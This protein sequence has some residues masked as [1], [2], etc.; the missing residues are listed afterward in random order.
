MVG[1][2]PAQFDERPI[3]ALRRSPNFGEHS[4]EVLAEL[5][6]DEHAIADL[7]RAGLVL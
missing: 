7:K 2:S 6:L 3:G 4:A 1:A 5:G